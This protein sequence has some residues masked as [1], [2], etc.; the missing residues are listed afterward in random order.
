MLL[1]IIILVDHLNEPL[2]N[3]GT[4]DGQGATWWTKYPSG[5]L[6]NVTR[7]CMIE[8]MYSNQIQISNL[9]LINS[10][11]SFVHPVYSRYEHASSIKF[12][13][14]AQMIIVSYSCGS[15]C[16]DILIQGLTILA[17]IDSPNTHGIQPGLFA[18]WTNCS[19]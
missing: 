19:H 1:Y 10:P 13:S 12:I 7:P 16:S 2:G 18:S 11:Y 4:I 15:D 5:G 9:I 3:N 17:P 6:L 8:L 14:N